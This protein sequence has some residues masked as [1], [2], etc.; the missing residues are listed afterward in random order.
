MRYQQRFQN[1][2]LM[3]HVSS[4]IER[5]HFDVSD[6]EPFI[7]TLCGTRE[8]QKEAI[9]VTL[10]YFLGG[11]YTNL[12]QLAE[13][14]FHAHDSLQQRYITFPKMEKFLKLPEQ[15]SCSIDLATATGKSYVM[16]AIARIMLAHGA[17]DR[18]LILCPSLTI[19]RGLKEK[20]HQL[21][22]DAT[23]RDLLPE[24][25]FIRN[26]HIINATESIVEGTICIENFHATLLHVKSSIRASLTGKGAKTLVLNDEAH[27]IYNPTK[28][29][30]RWKEFLLDPDF[31][32][33]YI[34]GFSGTCYN[35][36]EYFADV[37]YR[38][39]IRQAIEE[40][41]AKII[42][43]VAEDSSS[44]QDE[45]FQKI[46]DNHIQNRRVYRLVKPLTILVTR[47]ISDCK[48]LTN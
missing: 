7:D 47:D 6:Y 46:Y 21:S 11:R 9:R 41:Y 13:E 35:G 33:H 12:R 24:N 42:D 16:Y 27:H 1:E 44:S 8:Y 43:Y 48:E 38:Y 15:L 25:S 5:S 18:V 10:R 31:G 40:G 32:F 29:L 34:A 30:G 22:S 2:D 26:P 37:I 39:P 4:N 3:L 20:F 28:D 45:R 14:N 36:N 17:V 23:L 19:E